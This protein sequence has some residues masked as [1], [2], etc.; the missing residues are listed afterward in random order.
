M[1]K[2]AGC[3]SGLGSCSLLLLSTLASAAERV[4]WPDEPPPET[5]QLTSTPG[6]TGWL[7]DFYAQRLSNVTEEDLDELKKLA[8]SE[9]GIASSSN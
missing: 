8:E 9:D 7:M 5:A 3:V 1:H 4:P 2:R 6:P